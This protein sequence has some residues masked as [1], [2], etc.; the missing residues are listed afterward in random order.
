MRTIITVVLALTASSCSPAPP[1]SDLETTNATRFQEFAVTTPDSVSLYIRVVGTGPDTVIVGA[2]AWL[3]RDLTPLSTG[4]TLIFYDPR[5]RGASD[6]V[7]DPNRLGIDLEVQD[8]EAVRAHFGAGRISLIGW[9]YLGAVAALYAARFPDAVRSV[10]QVGPM[11]PRDELAL[12]SE[13]RGSPPPTADL[14]WLADLEATGLPQSNPVAYCREASRIRIIRPMLGRPEAVSRMQS[15][16]CTY[17]NEWPSQ[18][19]AT[20][21]KFIPQVRGE[22]WDYSEEASRVRAPVLTVHGTND[23]NAAVEGGREWAELFPNSELVELEGVGHAPWLEAP[24]EF[25]AAVRAFLDE[26]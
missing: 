22:S 4:R 10:V 19:F 16:P 25:F 18:A 1:S 6:Y 23:P 7:E 8:I 2:A 17:W 21:S 12:P 3:A 15:D 5:S 11:A 20:I 26:H 9:S 14:E 24:Q 13:P